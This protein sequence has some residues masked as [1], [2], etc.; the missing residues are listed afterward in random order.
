MKMAKRVNTN[1]KDIINNVF[2]KVGIPTNYA[3]KLIDELI[4]IIIKNITTKKIAKIKNF[5]VFTLKEK[6]KRV[7]RNPKNKVTHE[8]LKRNVVTFRV[9]E[10]LRRRINSNVK[11]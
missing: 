8:I 5:G 9:A 10:E 11:K 7:G 2:N 4:D 1:K 6:K 3:A